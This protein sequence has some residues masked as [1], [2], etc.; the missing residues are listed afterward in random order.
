MNRLFVYSL[1]AA[2]TSV[3]ASNSFAQDAGKAKPKPL[4][5]LLVTGGCCHEYAKQ[6]DILKKGLESRAMV[7]ISHVHTD[8]T[9]TKARFSLYDSPDWAKGYDVII[10]DECTSDVIEPQYVENILNAHKNGIPAVNLHCAMHSYRI[11]DRDDWF[12][13]VGIQSAKHGPQKPIEITFVDKEHPITKPLE[14]W[15]TINEELYN[16]LKLF[17]GTRELAWGKQDTGKTVDTYVVTWTNEFGKA[18]VF[19]TTI[20]HNTATVADDR[21]LDMVARGLLWSCDKLNPE[22]LQPFASNP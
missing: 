5:A 17:P 10:H 6:K 3:I 7:E 1:I 4:K 14:N 16:N 22:Y 11:K 13:F 15:T 9:T 21:Y 20:G 18:R 19:S 12:N 8:D 2:L